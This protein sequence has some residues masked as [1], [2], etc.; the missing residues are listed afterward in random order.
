MPEHAE[1]AGG[2]MLRLK[3]SDRYCAAL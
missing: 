3:D 2:F 1:P